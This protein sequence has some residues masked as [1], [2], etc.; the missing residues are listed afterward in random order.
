MKNICFLVGNLNNAG[1]IE[2]VTSVVA[3]AL[4]TKGYNVFILNL[5]DG[6]NPF[7]ELNPNIKI[8]CI[9]SKPVSFK[10]HYLT[11]IFAIRSFI[12]KYKINTLIVA[13]SISCIFTVAA[14]IGI[15]KVKH[16]CWEHFN[17][18]Y[19]LGLK[20]RDLGRKLA[21]KYCD[22]IVTLTNEDKLLWEKSLTSLE[23]KIVTI[24]NPTPFENIVNTP[25]LKHKTVLAVGRLT[26]QKGFDRLLE[27]WAKININNKHWTLKIVGNGEDKDKLIS[28]AKNLNIEN[29]V[30]FI[31]NTHSISQ[32]YSSCSMICMSSRFEGLPMVLI[33]AISFGL[34]IV[35]FNCKCGPSDLIE[36]NGNGYLVDNG[37][38]SQLAE[39]LDTM[40]NA[41][42][43]DYDKF[44]K[45]SYELSLKYYIDSLI[46]Q[47]IEI[48]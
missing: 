32:Y 40:I 38:I 1:G 22:I 19:N 16:I 17:Y 10:T 36:H 48:I 31:S 21:A 24:A 33:E 29:S 43:E 4:A 11:T 39:A 6:K 26:Y 20:L 46:K 35:S 37:D 27:A 42:P 15:K 25:S 8:D 12:V 47:W 45:K 3:N 13:D 23:A 14:L 2:R 34:P 41:S 7:F 18:D 9:F 28:Q 30:Q 5:I 44:I